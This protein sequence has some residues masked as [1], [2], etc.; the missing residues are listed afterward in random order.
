LIYIALSHHEKWNGTVYPRQLAYKN[1][2]IEARIVAL[3]DV[4]N[5]VCSIRPYKAALPE[6][7]VLEIIRADAGSHLDPD[8]CSVFFDWLDEVH[9]VQLKLSD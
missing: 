7:Q 5:T 6:P 3:A 9:N 4:Y 8:I 2:P 1:I